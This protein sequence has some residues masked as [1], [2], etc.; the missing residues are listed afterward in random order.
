MYMILRYQEINIGFNGIFIKF[1][2]DFH[3]TSILVDQKNNIKFLAI[4]I[5]EILQLK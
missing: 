5:I 1:L 4:D 2:S 3:L